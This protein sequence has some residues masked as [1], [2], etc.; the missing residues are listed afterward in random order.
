[1]VAAGLP[2]LVA[3][4]L[5]V[6]GVLWL[7]A[8]RR[9]HAGALS[10]GLLAAAVALLQPL[11]WWLF[12]AIGQTRLQ[13]VEEVLVLVATGAA[14]LVVR[15]WARRSLP[16][17]TSGPAQAGRASGQTSRRPEAPTETPRI[18]LSYRRD[19]SPDVTGRIYDRLR[20]GFGDGH[21]F[22]DVDSMEFGVDFRQ[23]LREVV[24]QCS[25][26]LAIIGPGWSGAADARGDRRLLQASDYVRLEIEAALQ[27][28]IPVIPVL[29]RGAAMPVEDDLPPTLAP[30]VYRNGISV[31]AD[32][33]FHR[34]MDRLMA[35]LARLVGTAGREH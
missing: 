14:A 26:Q 23:H 12:L 10:D 33:D 25:V 7:S 1:M 17:P 16:R 2:L 11:V 28:D 15:R 18:F 4:L 34:D 32:P 22:K 13:L 24:G 5:G 19:D 3:V 9:G 27:R 8:L 21:V 20:L 35:S 6:V 30:L 31:R 29:V